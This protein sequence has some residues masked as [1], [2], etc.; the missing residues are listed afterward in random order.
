MEH[1]AKVLKHIKD[2]TIDV[3]NI[4]MTLMIT[5]ILILNLLHST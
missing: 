2:I 1:W 5:T 4:E 3:M